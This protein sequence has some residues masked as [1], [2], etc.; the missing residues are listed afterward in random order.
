[1]FENKNAEDL[2]AKLKLLIESKETRQ[3][4][5]ENAKRRVKENFD[6]EIVT[7]RVVKIYQD[8]MNKISRSNG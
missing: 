6:I 2:K 4:F 3:K 7:D 5:G 8:E 1:L